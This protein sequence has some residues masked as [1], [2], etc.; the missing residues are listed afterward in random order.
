MTGDDQPATFHFLP[1]ALRPPGLMTRGQ[2]RTFLLVGLAALFAGYDQAVYGFAIPQ[3]QAS[4]HIPED[5]VGLTVG[6]FR[7]AAFAAIFLALTADIIGRR[8]LLLVTIFGQAVFTL[9]TAF[10]LTYSEFVWLQIFTRIFG[11]AEEMLC[12]VVVVEVVAAG[13]RGWA[14]G[15]LAMLTYTGA[16]LASLCYAFVTILPGHWRALY[17]IGGFALFFVA[18]L[19]RRLPETERF[20][21]RHEE[22]VNVGARIGGA[23]DMARRMAREYPGRIVLILIIV[24]AYGFAMSPAVVLAN[25]YLQ[26]T[27]HF[28][29]WQTTALVIPGGLIALWLN[30]FAGRMSDRFGRKPVTL[31]LM[32]TSGVCFALFYSGMHGWLVAPLWVLSYF[33]YF[34]SDALISGFALEIVP[35]AYRATVSGLRYAFNTAMGGVALGLEGVWYDTFH[36]HGP[37]ISISLLIIP[38]S[39]IGILFLPEPAGRELEEVAAAPTL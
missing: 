37:A 11:Y 9:A 2:L 26:Q 6:Y 29:P 8:R 33:A 28:A 15:A 30:V 19:R 23:F 21:V 7:I 31:L 10:S 13:V 5:Q 12:V 20:K 17:V 36:A 1:A 22:V 34:G 35:T 27:L 38:I 39:L 3:I 25:K 32:I 4:L 14:I 16:G 18:F 24:S